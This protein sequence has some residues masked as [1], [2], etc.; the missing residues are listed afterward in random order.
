[1]Y[2][3]RKH[4]ASL[5]QRL[6]KEIRSVAL[7]SNSKN[8][9]R[10]P[11]YHF[12]GAFIGSFSKIWDDDESNLNMKTK[13]RQKIKRWTET[14]RDHDESRRV[15]E[16]E[17]ETETAMSI[18]GEQQR[19]REKKIKFFTKLPWGALTLRIT[20]GKFTKQNGGLMTMRD[21]WTWLLSHDSRMKVIICFIITSNLS[22]SSWK[23]FSRKWEMKIYLQ[24]YK[25][26]WTSFIFKAED[27]I[28]MR[29][30]TELQKLVCCQT[31]CSKSSIFRYLTITKMDRAN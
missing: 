31:V 14:S 16:R 6:H 5:Q 24:N 8:I 26:S 22:I 21:E 2:F 23:C 20:D 30:C 18:D 17:K 1:M 28:S 10:Q 4:E 19:E 13:E 9:I 12:Y 15:K 11:V 27:N 3:L 7:P 29:F 25:S